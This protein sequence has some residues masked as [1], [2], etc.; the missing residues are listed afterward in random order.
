MYGYPFKYMLILTTAWQHRC[1]CSHPVEDIGEFPQ[2]LF[3]VDRPGR[4]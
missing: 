2:R 3:G 1:L 4:F